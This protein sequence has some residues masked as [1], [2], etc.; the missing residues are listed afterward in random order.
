[1]TKLKVHLMYI[2]IL[3]KSEFRVLIRSNV[4]GNLK[5]DQ[6]V[7]YR[8]IMNFWQSKAYIEGNTL[9]P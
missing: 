5:S 6:T 4:N 8:S 1:M 2:Y 3:Q 7:K 9:H